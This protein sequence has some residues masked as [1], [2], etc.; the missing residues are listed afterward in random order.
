[1]EDGHGPLQRRMLVAWNGEW[2]VVMLQNLEMVGEGAILALVQGLV[3]V[4][5]K[6]M[7][8]EVANLFA[9][10]QVEKVVDRN[11]VDLLDQR[12]GDC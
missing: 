2:V 7:E 4:L 6:K 10:R 1:M 8:K 9:N 11:Q 3:L 5:G 12:H